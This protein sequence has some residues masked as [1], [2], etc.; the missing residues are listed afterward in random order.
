EEQLSKFYQ[1]DQGESYQ[2]NLADLTPDKEADN[3]QKPANE[4]ENEP[5]KESTVVEIKESSDSEPVVKESADKEPANEP[6]TIVIN[7]QGD[8][9]TKIVDSD[10]DSD[11]NTNTSV[12][13]V[14]VTTTET[15]TNVS[16][17]GEPIEDSQ[18]NDSETDEPEEVAYQELSPDDLDDT[19]ESVQVAGDYAISG[20]DAAEPS[21]ENTENDDVDNGSNDDDEHG[22]VDEEMLSQFYAHDQDGNQ[23]E[24]IDMY[25]MD[26]SL[27]SSVSLD[28]EDDD[29]DNDG[30]VTSV[31]TTTTTTTTTTVVTETSS[32]PD[33]PKVMKIYTEQEMKDIA[34]QQLEKAG[35]TP[36]LALTEVVSEDSPEGVI[37]G[38]MH[39]DE[40]FVEF[41]LSDGEDFN[42][43]DSEAFG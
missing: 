30:T 19:D 3:A 27:G 23:P 31:T 9:F 43:P 5:E 22:D 20:N 24:V 10:T 34:R 2:S 29:D 37:S 39:E 7:D 21:D 17:L 1:Q 4:P 42:D 32:D 6:V 26:E 13:T 14:T 11:D 38:E 25:D 18:N 40:E 16:I 12:E 15:T 33:E 8:T 41:G 36:D 28:V 35:V